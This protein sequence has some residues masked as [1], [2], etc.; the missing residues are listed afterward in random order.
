MLSACQKANDLM[1]DSAQQIVN[2]TRLTF[3]GSDSIDIANS[4]NVSP[5]SL[6][7]SDSFLVAL[8]STQGFS[9]LDVKVTNDSGSVLFERPFSSLQGNSVGG[10]F[11]FIPSSIYV[12]YLSYTFTPY[13]SNGAAGNQ[14]MKLVRLFNSKDEAPVVDSVSAPDSLKINQG[15]TVTTVL[16]AFVHDQFG[17]NDIARVYFNVTKP[18]GTPASSNPNI[19]YN[20]G[21]ASGNSGDVDPVAN[22]GQYTLGISLPSGTSK[23]TY[24]F[25]F[26]GVNRS[27]VTG[28]PFSHKITVY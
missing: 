9:Y 14:E 8:T 18:D 13:D 27:G 4:I 20:D 1:I 26:Y 19:M 16:T 3:V 21:G 7:I 23:G 25:T 10:S 15:G 6:V 22:D 5:P 12:G 28:Y 2:A 24:I 11:D 17:L